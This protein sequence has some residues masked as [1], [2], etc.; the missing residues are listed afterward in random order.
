MSERISTL[1]VLGET[2]QAT[3]RP[4]SPTGLGNIPT[5]PIKHHGGAIFVAKGETL[6]G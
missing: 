1:I 3:A 4:R 5:H 2:Q 6:Q